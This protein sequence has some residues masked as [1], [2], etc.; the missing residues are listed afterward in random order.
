MHACR[1]CLWWGTPPAVTHFVV[2]Q[3]WYC[4]PARPPVTAVGVLYGGR[5]ALIDT[6]T[7]L[8]A[9]SRGGSSSKPALPPLADA[10]SCYTLTRLPAV[11]YCWPAR[12]PVTA[13]GIFHGGRDVLLGFMRFFYLWPLGDVSLLFFIYSCIVT[14]QALYLGGFSANP[15]LPPLADASSCC[16]PLIVSHVVLLARSLNC[17]SCRGPPTVLGTG[18]ALRALIL[19]VPLG[20]IT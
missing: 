18:N 17:D 9:L 7:F 1:P 5:D 20:C 13:V 4:S 12:S 6:Q 2:S 8:P 11:L 14:L 10:S 19:F 3:C 16:T 15:A